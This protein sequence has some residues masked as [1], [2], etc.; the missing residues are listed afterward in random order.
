MSA[1]ASVAVDTGEALVRAAWRAIEE[2]DWDALPRYFGADYVRHSGPAAHSFDEFRQL[3]RAQHE[4]F[5]DTKIVLSDFV[6]AGEHVAFRWSAT[7]THKLPYLEIPATQRPVEL[8][9]ITIS[10]IADGKIVEDWAS[11]NRSYLL[12]ALG[13][14]P[15]DMRSGA[16]AAGEASPGT[17][18]P[19][20]LRAV[21]RQFGT[22]VTVVT[23]SVDEKPAGLV[24]NAF[25]SICLEPPLVLVSIAETAA[26]YPA[27]FTNDRIAVNILARDQRAIAE[28]CARSGGDKFAEIPWRPGANGAPLVDGAAASIEATVVKRIPSYTH[29]IFIAHV[30][31][32]TSSDRDPLLYL[33]GAFYDGGALAAAP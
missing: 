18:D 24:V 32:A 4:A 26:T 10:R 3:I 8:W 27:L 20:A 7:G 30:S 12:E 22:G 31:D 15:I 23:T 19:E 17:V 29:T 1:P 28:R 13:I 2:H 25:S 16:A 9:G 33:G 5:P 21:H 14:T 11:W 6:V